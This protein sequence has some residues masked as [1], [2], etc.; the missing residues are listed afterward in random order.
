M[1]R[2]WQRLAALGV[3]VALLGVGTIGASA[4]DGATPAKT[5]HRSLFGA[6]QSRV[7]QVSRLVGID[8]ETRVA[9]GTLDDGKE[10]L[11][12]AKIGL[13]QAIAAA[14]GAASGDVG[15]VDLEHFHGRLVFNV[16]V[17]NR[18]VKVDATDGTV[19]AAVSD[20]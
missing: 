7:E 20:D 4:F 5:T 3:G 18:D 14:Q 19:L 16:D 17:G 2:R 9:P 6:A 10:L 13:A 8:D 1:H 15:E 11:P 12:Q